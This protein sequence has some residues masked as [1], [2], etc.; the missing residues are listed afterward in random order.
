MI[1]LLFE[2]GL[3]QQSGM[4][5]APLSWQEIQAWLATTS[6]QLTTWEKLTLKAMSEAYA[7]EY[8]QA[9]DKT[10]P[11]PY[12][13]VPEDVDE[14]IDRVAIGNKLKSLFRSLKKQ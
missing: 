3:V 8:N 2:A 9:S 6:L 13:F 7:S 11:A 14:D 4:G 5:V 10:R 1:S 12:V